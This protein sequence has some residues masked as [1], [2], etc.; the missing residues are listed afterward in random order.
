[1]LGSAIE[2]Y[3]EE[4]LKIAPIGEDILQDNP[5]VVSLVCLLLVLELRFDLLELRLDIWVM[6]WELPQHREVLQA[7]LRFA[8][9]D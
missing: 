2:A 9:V 3:Q 6:G 1:M 5:V 4:A 7:L 8:V